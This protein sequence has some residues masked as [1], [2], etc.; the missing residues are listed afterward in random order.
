M[1][2]TTKA[3]RG[4]TRWIRNE[5]GE[6]RFTVCIHPDDVAA[7]RRLLGQQGAPT[8][9]VILAAGREM[10]PPYSCNGRTQT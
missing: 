8:T 3:I 6:H 2:E 9:A 10:E 7:A 1:Q 5:E 4:E